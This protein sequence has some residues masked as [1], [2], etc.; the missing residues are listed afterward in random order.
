MQKTWHFPDA[1]LAVEKWLTSATSGFAE[2]ITSIP[3]ASGAK[4]RLDIADLGYPIK[5]FTISLR[6]D[7][8]AKPCE[9]YVDENHCLK[10]PHVESDGKVCLGNDCQPEDY[11]NPVQAV[12]R[13]IDEFRAKLLEKSIDA[14][15]T[16]REF[17]AE[18][19][20]YWT[21][22][23]CRCTQG[24]SSKPLPHTTYVSAGD[25]PEWASASIAA[26]A[27]AGSK[28][29]RIDIQVVTLEDK[30]PEAL[31]R[32]H[33]WNTGTYVRGKALFVRLP[34]GQ[35]W[36]P[37][38][39]PTT[40]QEL[41]DLVR[42]ATDGRLS[43]G[44]WLQSAAPVPHAQRYSP[45][46]D[47]KVAIGLHP[48]LIVLCLGTEFYG[49]QIT[50]PSIS[51]VAQPDVAPIVIQRVDPSWI[52]ARDHKTTTFSK[53]LEKRV[54]L[55]GCGSLGSPIAEMLAR[56]GV[57]HLDIVDKEVFDGPNVARHILGMTAMQ[58]PK[59]RT[60]AGRLT[61]AIPRV[62]VHGYCDSVQ[63]WTLKNVRAGRYDLV[64]DCTADSGVRTFVAQNRLELF[65]TAPVV[66][67]WVE[68]YCA[69]THV[70]AS[71]VQIPWP[72]HDPVEQSVSAAVYPD[73]IGVKLPACNGGFH[74]YGS[75]DIMQAAG[76][77]A[78]RVLTLIDQPLEESTVWSFVRSKAFF[79]GLGFP[80]EA[81]AIV[82][83]SGGPHDGYSLTRRLEE[84]LAEQ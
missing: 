38:A 56:S 12:A 44:D 2:R 9:L 84:V 19:M 3:V 82:L 69:A 63:N 80:V 57:G 73:D 30:E 35:V 1:F 24:R 29:P 47:V 10:L 34:P 42:N 31:A 78:E 83:E 79:D 51:L 17:H 40:F 8:P 28:S 36:T 21:H 25:F 13:A 22:F 14:I 53:R 7:F 76:F 32:R 61:K 26:Y 16:E 46:D 74:P 20:A 4:W 49:Y 71:T 11:A 18:R 77:C 39:W 33:G 43:A 45:R 75:A 50:P 66:H 70:V 62:A 58:L 41:L 55:L 52:L 5:N 68:P 15:W 48:L 67:A 81:K 65:G 60:V 59:A 23:C 27:R 72:A 64:V 54:L 37:S 6:P